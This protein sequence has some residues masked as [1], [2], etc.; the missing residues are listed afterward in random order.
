MNLNAIP[1]GNISG[2]ESGSN[3]IF[4]GKLLE[5]KVKGLPNEAL[6]EVR[7]WHDSKDAFVHLPKCVVTCFSN[8]REMFLNL[9]K[10]VAVCLA[11]CALVTD[12]DEKSK[13]PRLHKIAARLESLTSHLNLGRVL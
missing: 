9:P 3:R 4:R 2:Y 10:V 7:F 8:Y 1:V 5:R 13:L 11:T 6:T 12:L